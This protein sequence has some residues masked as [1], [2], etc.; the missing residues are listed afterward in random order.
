MNIKSSKAV[1]LADCYYFFVAAEKDSFS[2]VGV[3]V[4]R[5]QRCLS[6]GFIGPIAH[7]YASNDVE[8]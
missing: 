5:W 1:L 7:K 4:M 6:D 2:F 3:K 8:Q